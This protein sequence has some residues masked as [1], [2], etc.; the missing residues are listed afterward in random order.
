MVYS[1]QESSPGLKQ[2][3]KNTKEIISQT[4]TDPEKINI[5]FIDDDFIGYDNMS[6]EHD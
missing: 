6:S 2:F 3:I 1:P 4:S 5:A